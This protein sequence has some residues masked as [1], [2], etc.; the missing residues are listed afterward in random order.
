MNKPRFKNFSIVLPV[1]VIALVSLTLYSFIHAQEDKPLFTENEY[2]AHLKYLADDLLEGRAPGTRGGDLAALYIASQFEAA[3]L[4]PISEENGYFQ[5]VPLIK[6]T[7]DYD[8]FDFKLS[9]EDKSRTLTAAEDFIM[10]SELLQEEIHLEEDVVFVGYGIDAPEY[11]WNDFKDVD[12]TGKILLMIIGT[13]GHEQTGFGTE[14]MSWYVFRS[15][16]SAI[17]RLKGAKGFIV[18]HSDKIARLPFSW[19]Q[20]NYIPSVHILDNIPKKPVCIDGFVSEPAIDSALSL[21]GLSFDQLKQKADSRDFRPFPIGLKAKIHFKQEYQKYTSPNVIG[22]LPGSSKNEA[23]IY[24]A[25]YDHLGIGQPVN[26]DNIYNGAGDNA[27]GTSALICLARAFASRPTARR[28]IIFC[29]FTAHEKGMRG[30]KYYVSHPIFP[31]EK[32]V[33]G[34]NMDNLDFL[35]RMDGFWMFLIS[36]TN[37]IPI[38]Q[39]LGKELG[40]ELHYS[41]RRS[42]YIAY[43]GDHLNFWPKGVVTLSF[44]QGGKLLDL[45][46]E[47]VEEFMEEVG[48]VYHMPSDEIYPFFRYE[49]IIQSMEVLFH[50]GQYYANDRERPSMNPEN[51]YIPRIRIEEM[52]YKDVIKKK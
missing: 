44:S 12:V 11:E 4:Q 15:Y 14:N 47:E 43:R 10:Y 52:L 32:T 22:M 27:S 30:S 25:H 5:Q 34:F 17:T 38:F 16:K 51:P 48:D 6:I 8:S 1:I 31:L 3:G 41:Q 49:G 29:A 18:I 36:Y 20:S 35:G 13:P 2:K 19:S 9:S 26:G 40:L 46:D 45:T 50:F 24:M 28:S 23:V 42:S 39:K 33:I 21:V 37:A 7:T